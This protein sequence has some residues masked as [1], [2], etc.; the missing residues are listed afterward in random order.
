[1][2]PAEGREPG[3]ILV[4]LK[5]VVPGKFPLLKGVGRLRPGDLPPE[6]TLELT[7]EVESQDQALKGM[8]AQ[9]QLTK[10]PIVDD[11]DPAAMGILADSAG[12]AE[13]LG[14]GRVR[15]RRRIDLGHMTME[16]TWIYI[17]FYFQ[18]EGRYIVYP[19]RVEIVT[20]TGERRP[21]QG[22]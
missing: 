14:Q 1:M 15:Y 21:L 9:L 8:A 3:R 6:G 13:D 2:L 20:G 5:E 11:A 19:P 4:D 12:P 17:D 16:P 7:W 22:G 10:I 18:G